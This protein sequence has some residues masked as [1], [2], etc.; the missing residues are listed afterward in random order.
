[1]YSTEMCLVLQS[2]YN[3]TY[4]LN[5]YLK[6][7]FI[8]HYNIVNSVDS[9]L[10]PRVALSICLSFSSCLFVFTVV[11]YLQAPYDAFSDGHTGGLLASLHFFILKLE[12]GTFVSLSGCEGN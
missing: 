4:L 5:M 1:M 10:S 8:P 11:K 7:A 6:V 9:A 3:P 2:N 12:Y